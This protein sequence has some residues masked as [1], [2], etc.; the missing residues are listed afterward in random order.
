M[1]FRSAQPEVGDE[2]LRVSAAYNR[3]AVATGNPQSDPALVGHS[4]LEANALGLGTLKYQPNEQQEVMGTAVWANGHW[5]VN[6]IRSASTGQSDDIELGAARRIPVAFAVW[7]GSKGD[8]DGIKL[9][10][11]WHWL[12]I[13][14]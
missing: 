2:D 4:V 11:G 6:M 1:L 10:S 7:D 9:I 8:R 5:F 12:V 14:K 13:E 3:S